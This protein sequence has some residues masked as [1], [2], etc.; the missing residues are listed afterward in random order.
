MFITNTGR[1]IYRGLTQ[2]NT[3]YI[4]DA[5][6]YNRAAAGKISARYRHCVSLVN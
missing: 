2:M 6:L 5:A 4:E 1:L 3:T